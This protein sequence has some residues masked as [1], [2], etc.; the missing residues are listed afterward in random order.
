MMAFQHS[1]QCVF[2]A[3]NKA[4][5]AVF[6]SIFRKAIIVVPLAILLPKIPMLGVAGVFMA[7]PISNFVGGLACYTTMNRTV[8]KKL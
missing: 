8:I 2:K 7:E 4:K 3:L 1:G 5:H 6:F